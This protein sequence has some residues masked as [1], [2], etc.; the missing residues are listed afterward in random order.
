MPEIPIQLDRRLP[1]SLINHSPQ[2]FIKCLEALPQ[3]V[4]DLDIDELAKNAYPIGG[5]NSVPS[6]IFHLRLSL[7]RELVSTKDFPAR[8]I[9]IDRVVK[10]ICSRRHFFTLIKDPY[11]FAM[12][13]LPP[14]EYS[15]QMED[16][17]QLSIPEMRRIL[18]LPDTFDPMSG[19]VDSRLL[20]VKMKLFMYIDTRQRGAVTQKTESKNLNVTIEAKPEDMQKFLSVEDIDKRLAELEAISR[21]PVCLPPA[22]DILPV[23]RVVSDNGGRHTEG[24]PVEVN[25]IGLDE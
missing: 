10:G 20:A 12:I 15:I 18:M 5:L 16:L 13:L 23:M 24:E 8:V 25:K 6:K 7:E 3:E 1:D 21:E 2:E 19:Q 14:G 17:L 4:L 11:I 22:R 9:D